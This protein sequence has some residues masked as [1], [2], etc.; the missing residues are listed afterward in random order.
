[1]LVVRETVVRELWIDFGKIKDI[2]ISFQLCFSS[3]KGSI[4]G[5]P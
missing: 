4:S 5:C 1:M 2:A 3:K